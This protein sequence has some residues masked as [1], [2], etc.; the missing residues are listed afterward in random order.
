MRRLTAAGTLDIS[1][2]DG[3]IRPG[4]SWSF[5]NRRSISESQATDR[6]TFYPN[7]RR[8]VSSGLRC[9]RTEAVLLE[10]DFA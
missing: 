2:L 1:N 5:S 10:Q 3:T 9:P 6:S 8:E 7:A 4:G